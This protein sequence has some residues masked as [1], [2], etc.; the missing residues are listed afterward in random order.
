MHFVNSFRRNIGHTTEPIMP[1]P[2]ICEFEI[3]VKSNITF[4]QKLSK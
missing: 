2:S 4:Q 3:A 1:E